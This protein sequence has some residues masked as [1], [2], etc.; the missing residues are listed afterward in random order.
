MEVYKVR[1][2]KAYE[3]IWDGTYYDSPGDIYYIAFYP[4][5]IYNLKIEDNIL[6]YTV[7]DTNDSERICEDV[8]FVEEKDMNEYFIIDIKET[9]KIKL[10]KINES[11]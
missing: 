9:R 7:Y 11:R 4:D 1:C 5:E 8:Y 2:I 3:K 6:G 10:Q